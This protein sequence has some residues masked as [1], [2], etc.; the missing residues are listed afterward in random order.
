MGR[1]EHASGRS[2]ERPDQSNN[3]AD[4]RGSAPAR[5]CWVANGR[6]WS[7]AR[8]RSHGLQHTNCVSLGQE[9]V[10]ATG[11]EMASSIYDTAVVIPWAFCGRCSGGGR[12]PSLS[13]DRMFLV[14]GAQDQGRGTTSARDLVRQRKSS[15]VCEKDL[16]PAEVDALRHKRCANGNW[17]T[18]LR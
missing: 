4:W 8:C 18:P 6:V 1:T 15:R 2:A 11:L 13:G 3:V 10:S 16:F 5:P 17:E 7:R 12:L 9:V 14:S